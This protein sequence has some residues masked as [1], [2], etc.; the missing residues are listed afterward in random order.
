MALPYLKLE[1]FFTKCRIGPYS[2][3]VKRREI[4]AEPMKASSKQRHSSVLGGRN[5]EDEARVRLL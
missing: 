2:R 4:E 3:I 5:S 1:E